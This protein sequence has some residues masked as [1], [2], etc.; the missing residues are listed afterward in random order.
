MSH[1]GCDTILCFGD[2]LTQRGWD[3]SRNGWVAQLSQ[4][5]VR[6]L[7]V[8]SRGY[9]G[10]NSRWTLSLLPQILPTTDSKGPRPRLL[11]I[12]LGSNDAFLPGLKQHVP[13]DEYKSNIES[14]VTMVT[15][16]Q[17][18][19]YSPDT[20]ILLITPPALGEKL[21]SSMCDLYVGRTPESVKACADVMR[22]IAERHSL[23]CVDLWT[24]VETQAKEVGGELDGYDAFSFDGVHLNEGG[25]DLLFKLVLQ[26]I[27]QHYPELDPSKVPHV[28]PLLA[29]LTA[30]I[31]ENED[32]D[33]A[34]FLKFK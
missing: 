27:K 11:T 2:S 9:G 7:D 6:K 34:Q 31:K 25:N 14:M 28:V 26:T 32:L 23:P 3:V 4:A 30:A 19:H 33:V 1:F 13:I 18:A 8:V 17:S 15:D 29:E 5:Y 20:K 16:P 24:A 21:Y 12:L 22:D 10:Y